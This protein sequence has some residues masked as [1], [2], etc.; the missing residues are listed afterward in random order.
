MFFTPGS[1]QILV[2]CILAAVV[3]SLDVAQA[4]DDKP[5]PF[6]PV[7]PQAGQQPPTLPPAV[8]GRVLFIGARSFTPEQLQA[9]IAEQLKD[10]QATG[11]TKARADDTAYYLATY[12]RKQG[13]SEAEV[14]W[15]IRGSQ[16]ILKIKE[17]PR[18]YLRNVIFRG[19]RS[20]PDSTLYEYM[21][22]ATEERLRK[23][24]QQFPF[25]EADAKTGVSRVRGLYESEGYLEAV[26]DDPVITYTRDR[27]GADVLVRITEGPRYG[28]DGIAFTGDVLF[29]RE[30]LIKGLGESVDQPYSTQRVNTMQRNLQ[31]FYKSR[32]YYMAEVQVES[33]PK[34]AIPSRRK[35]DGSGFDKLVPVRF[36]IKA[37]SLYHFDGVTVKGLDQLKPSF[38]QNRF[39]KL[40]GQVYDPAKLDETYRELLRTGLFTNLRINSVPQADKTIRLDVTVEEAKPKEFGVSVGFSSY[41][42]FIL[43]LRLA[44]RNMFGSGRPLSL[45]VQRSQRS[46]RAE[47]LYIDPWLFES[48][49]SLRARLYAQ[50]RN[51]TGYKKRE[52]GLRGDLSR[53]ITKNIEF[54]TFLQLENVEITEF[55]IDPEFMGPTAYQIATLGFTQN[56]DFR[57]N[58]LNPSRGWVVNTSLDLDAIA[59]EVAFARGTAR[60]SYYWP[61]GKKMLLGAGVRGGLIFPF[62]EVPID[63]RFFLGG[64]TTVR[65]FRER[66][67]GP[68][69]RHGNPIGGEAYTTFNLEL[70]F[71]IWN[72]LHGAVF[73]DSGNLISR[74]EDV[75][76]DDMR[77]A[78]GVGLRYKLPIGPVRLDVGFNPAPRKHETW[79]AVHFSFGFAF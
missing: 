65:S 3:T 9:A 50:D 4:Q 59:G 56:Y 75:G 58:P 53:K 42:G 66:E 20:I 16:L 33:D 57:D 17:G 45:E 62:T 1:P 15:E 29:P 25:V 30:E 39:R 41:E 13:Y 77:F 63:E 36:T 72:A 40:T 5:A 47:L 70:D 14:N 23:E 64:A 55:V 68:K 10:I 38:I 46:L 73:I 27:S 28:F 2:A 8:T 43:G 18:T 35:P 51:E 48:D 44:N 60:L 76:L 67:L 78:L 69:D 71:P 54:S 31:F 11:L 37:G 26:I 32:G 22:G 24:P 61:V 34:R 6:Q 74:H 12:Y 19:N 7:L 79:G 52:T 21:V 49:Y